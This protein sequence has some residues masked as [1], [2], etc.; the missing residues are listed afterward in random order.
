MHAHLIWH[1]GIAIDMGHPGVAKYLHF[2]RPWK[3]WLPN[4]I[5]EQRSASIATKSVSSLSFPGRHNNSELSTLTLSVNSPVAQTL[6]MSLNE[7][8]LPRVTLT[9]GWQQVSVTLSKDAIQADNRIAFRWAKHAP[10]ANTKKAFAAISWLALTKEPAP[11][12]TPI[13]VLVKETASLAPQ[14]GIA[15]YLH[16]YSGAKLVV[17]ATP[18]GV[19]K[20]V[21]R[22]TTQVDDRAASP[23]S[24][25]TDE[26]TH[27]FR[28]RQRAYFD[29]ATLENKV[30]RLSLT[31][32]G[33]ECQSLSITKAAIVMPGSV[34]KKKSGKRPENVLFWLIDNARADRYK[35]YNPKS[36]VETPVINRLAQEGTL[37]NSRT[38]KAPS[39]A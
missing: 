19:C 11:K 7:K 12:N 13:N 27:A 14:N 15:Y 31:A 23:K 3:T 34:P 4:Q 2:R 1:G 22:A 33:V 37:S 17:E 30:G 5:V 10:L 36:R 9:K 32:Q 20:L 6:R 26:Q 35:V 24:F 8:A 38:F 25:A 18:T 29:L 21:V 28:S 16:P 39:R